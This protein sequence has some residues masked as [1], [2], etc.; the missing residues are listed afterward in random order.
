MI[1]IPIFREAPLDFDGTLDELYEMWVKHVL[2]DS[3]IVEEFHRQFC[4]YYLGDPDPL[5]L[6]RMVTGLDRG[7]TL[8][9]VSGAQLRPTDNSPAWWIHYKLFTGEFTQVDSFSSLVES[10]PCHMFQIRLPNNVSQAGWHVAHI[11]DAKDRNVNY[12][13]WDRAELLRRAVRNIH[14][15]NYFYVPKTDWQKYGGDAT[16]IAFFYEKFKA[17]YS[18][19]WEDFLRLIGGKQSFGGI[20]IDEYRYS[21]SSHQEEHGFLPKQKP[22]FP[23]VSKVKEDAM[24]DTD[25]YMAKYEFTRLCFKAEIIEPLSL[26]DRFCVVTP[27]GNYGM[28]KRE[29]YETFPNVVESRSYQV[30][31]IYHY[32]MTPQKAIRFKVD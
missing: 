19:I 9:T 23:M 25:A 11:F 8:R 13:G 30:D 4:T 32:R 24:T 20:G 26:D 18:P 6:V 27:E 12:R 29:F 3:A 17:L 5:F 10:I 15:C 22:N 1:L 14:P 31:K 2:L 7:Q 16:V 28:T 21:F